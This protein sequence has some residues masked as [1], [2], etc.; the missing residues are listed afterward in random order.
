MFHIQIPDDALIKDI[1]K[2]KISGQIALTVASTIE[3]YAD[4][5][6]H[7][8]MDVFLNSIVKRGKYTQRKFKNIKLNSKDHARIILNFIWSCAALR[9]LNFKLTPIK[10]YKVEHMAFKVTPT[11][12][13]VN[14][15]IS[16]NGII[17]MIRYFTGCE[18]Q[19]FKPMK[20]SPSM[21]TFHF[22]YRGEQKEDEEHQNNDLEMEKNSSSMANLQKSCYSPVSERILPDMNMNSVG[23][24]ENN[25]SN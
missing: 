2:T 17:S 5:N 10:K 21:G 18:T 20:M 9:S 7:D 6:Y 4:K 24:I 1:I 14:S 12:D 25:N 11:L 19:M 8:M 3:F 22:D 13:M 23:G 15:M 16:A